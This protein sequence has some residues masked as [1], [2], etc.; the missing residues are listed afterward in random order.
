MK[1]SLFYEIQSIARESY[2]AQGLTR[3][4]G[5]TFQNVDG[6]RGTY[7]F[8]LQCYGR[9]VCPKG[10]TIIRETNGPHKR[11]IW[12]TQQQLF[13]SRNERERLSSFSS[14]SSSADASSSSSSSNNDRNNGNDNDNNNINDN[15]DD[16]DIES[17]KISLISKLDEP[18]WYFALSKK[19]EEAVLSSSSSSPT[20]SSTSSSGPFQLLQQIEDFLYAEQE[21]FGY[22]VIYPPLD[23]IFNAF[24]LCSLNDVKVVIIGQDPYHTP[25]VAHGLAFSVLSSSLSSSP[26]SLPP[27]LKNIIQEARDDVNIRIP[28]HGNLQHWARQGVLLLNTVLSVRQGQANSHSKHGWEEFTDHIIEILNDRSKYYPKS[29]TNNGGDDSDDDGINDDDGIVFLLWGNPA[30]KKAKIVNE[31]KHVIIRTSHPSPLG[32]TKTSSPFLG[33]KCFSRTNEALI[34]MGKTPIDWNII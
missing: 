29:G 26:K 8:E 27:S 6:N 31:S 23:T 14:T 7:E 21:Q 11:T 25:N 28:K 3:K 9:S 34:A 15:D 17:R 18:S 4:Y 13:M 33:S 2:T 5:G 20:S 22:D 19:S 10:N 12:Y 1:K 32:A 30:A 16:G 24:Q